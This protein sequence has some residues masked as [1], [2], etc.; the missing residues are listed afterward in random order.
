MRQMMA[1]LKLR[2][3]EDKTHVSRLPQEHFDFLSYTFGRC[4][5]TKTGR[6]YLGT[7]PS[8]DSIRCMVAEISAETER[9]TTG[10][11]VEDVVESLNCKL[12]GWANYFCLGPVSKAYRAIDAH[13]ATRL[14]RWLCK[15]H[16]TGRAARSCYPDEYLYE[17]L[18]LVRLSR[19]TQGF[20]WA[21]A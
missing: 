21:K 5:S 19:L 3:N 10:R 7:R 14:R 17:T 6:A 8:R 4:Y 20:A 16:K 9:R 12:E 15:K 13:T 11:K 18:G 1:W 2:V